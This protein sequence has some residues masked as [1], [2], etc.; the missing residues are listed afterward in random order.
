M[1]LGKLATLYDEYKKDHGIKDVEEEK[2]KEKA[3]A[4]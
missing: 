4:F 3:I 1:T 2:P